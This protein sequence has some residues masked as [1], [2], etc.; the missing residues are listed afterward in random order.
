MWKKFARGFMCLR[1]EAGCVVS[2]WR[3]Q[4]AALLSGCCCVS[5]FCDVSSANRRIF[6]HS[7]KLG[8]KNLKHET[9]VRFDVYPNHDE[10]WY[11]SSEHPPW[12]LKPMKG[13]FLNM[14]KFCGSPSKCQQHFTQV[15]CAVRRFRAHWWLLD[16]L[17][18]VHWEEEKT[19][20][21]WE[22]S[23]QL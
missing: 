23:R 2:W 12:T 14:S 7:T 20:K 9:N 6:H 8:K 1:D 4:A 18:R 13:K 15:R 22:R 21:A 19:H 5:G 16:H 10:N 3:Y 17:F 11:L